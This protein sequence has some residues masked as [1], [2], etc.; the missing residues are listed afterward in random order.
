MEN[1]VQVL[2]VEDEPAEL[3]FALREL[4]RRIPRDRIAVARD[5]E[6]ALNFLFGGGSHGKPSLD[7]LKLVLLDLK[8]PKV[9]GIEV[10]REIKSRPETKALPV[11][12]MTSSAEEKDL[13]ACYQLGANSY[14]QKSVDFEKFQ[15][16]IQALALYWAEINQMPSTLMPE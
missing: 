16:V 3:Q 8:L 11:V 9:D 6:E 1:Q 13:L 10:L 4:T 12:V 7:G 14:V 5:G 2:L 15:Q